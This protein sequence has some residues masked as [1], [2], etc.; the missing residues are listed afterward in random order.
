MNLLGL[1]IFG[2][3][4]ILIILVHY[5]L[6]IMSYAAWFPEKANSMWL[7]AKETIASIIR[8]SIFFRWIVPIHLMLV[9][10]V[11]LYSITKI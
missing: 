7:P 5:L 6:A 11:L 3:G 8:G 4:A 9:I 2:V 1:I 10:S